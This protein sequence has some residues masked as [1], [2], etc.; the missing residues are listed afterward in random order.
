MEYLLKQLPL[1]EL[2][3]VSVDGP[4]AELNDWKKLSNSDLR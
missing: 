4:L 3:F 2:M 1:L